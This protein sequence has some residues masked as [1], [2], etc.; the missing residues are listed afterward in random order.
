MRLRRA[1]TA[2]EVLVILALL[3]LVYGVTAVAV[4]GG[5]AHR[6]AASLARAL[7]SV[8]WLAVTTGAPVVLV[9]HGDAV[10]KSVGAPLR[11]DVLSAGEPVWSPN[12]PLVLTWPAS[13]I[14]FGAHG[15]PLRCDG[16]AAGNAT[17]ALVGRDGSSAAVIVA[18]LGRVRWERR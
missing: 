15:R 3:A 9:V 18:S 7:A 17:I 8:R 16:S 1:L 12:R 10:Y 4:G 13:G 5:S 11:C 2:I 14:A 6:D